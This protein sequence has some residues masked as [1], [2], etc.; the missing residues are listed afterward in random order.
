MSLGSVIK[1]GDKDRAGELQQEV[2]GD[3]KCVK[4]N[5]HIISSATRQIMSQKHKAQL[6]DI[7]KNYSIRAG[8]DLDYTFIIHPESIVEIESRTHGVIFLLYL[9]PEFTVTDYSRYAL[10]SVLVNKASSL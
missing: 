5:A 4:M 2:I 6:Q 8:L 10:F 7:I 1:H 3:D 9:S